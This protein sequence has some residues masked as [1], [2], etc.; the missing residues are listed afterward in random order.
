VARGL[1]FALVFV[2]VGVP[3]A[4]TICQATCESHDAGD[5]AGHAH[6]HSDSTAARVVAA[7]VPA[8][9]HGCGHQVD[10]AL[11]VQQTVHWLTWPAAVTLQAFVF[12][13]G[14]SH[15]IRPQTVN[16]DQSPPGIIVLTAQLR[17]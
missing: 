1:A 12:Q 9:P 17:V 2:I 10:D 5:R 6:H 3:V 14:A 13:P 4:A 16:I 15:T 8:T 11:A 7:T